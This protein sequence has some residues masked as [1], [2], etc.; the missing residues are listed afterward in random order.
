M[1]KV[2]PNQLYAKA[3][4]KNFEILVGYD[5]HLKR[6][7]VKIKKAEKYMFNKKDYYLVKIYFVKSHSL[8]S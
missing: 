3:S 5:L 4:L 8:I 1:F 7:V 6:S 2:I